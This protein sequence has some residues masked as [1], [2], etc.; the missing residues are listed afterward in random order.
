MELVTPE[1]GNK[2][3]HTNS[4]VCICI[5]RWLTVIKGN[6]NILDTLLTFDISVMENDSD[7]Q[8]TFFGVTVCFHAL[9]WLKSNLAIVTCMVA[10][11]NYLLNEY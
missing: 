1:I 2:D 4:K 6:K 7:F 8:Y 5:N 10:A 11:Y 3:T 9:G